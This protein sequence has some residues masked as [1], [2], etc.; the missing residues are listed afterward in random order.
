M[1]KKNSVDCFPS[2]HLRIHFTFWIDLLNRLFTEDNISTVVD[3]SIGTFS[4]LIA[5]VQLGCSYIGLDTLSSRYKSMCK[6]N[7]ESL[8]SLIQTNCSSAMIINF[9]DTQ[10]Q[11][12]DFAKSEFHVASRTP[13]SSST[14]N[15]PQ[16]SA[17]RSSP[18]EPT[19]DSQAF[20]RTPP[21]SMEE[22]DGKRQK[23]KK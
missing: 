11:N 15:T 6:S 13:P 18:S 8:T 22:P 1:K 14:E 23:K 16:K 2:A 19:Q 4:L 7:Y 9:L 10:K 21:P 17:I 12:F 20:K 5:A 3:C